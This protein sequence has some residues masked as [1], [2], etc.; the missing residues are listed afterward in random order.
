MASRPSPWATVSRQAAC[1][2]PSRP[3][4]W[5]APPWAAGPRHTSPGGSAPPS[6]SGCDTTASRPVAAPA[7]ATNWPVRVQT[8][9]AGDCFG[10]HVPQGRQPSGGGV[11]GE[12]RQ[13]VVAAVAHIQELPRRREVNL[14]ARVPGGV[15][16]GQ[17]RER[18]ESGEGARRRVQTIGRHT[19]PVLVRKIDDRKGGMKAIVAG[20]R[21]VAGS[22]WSG[23]L[24]VR[25]PVWASNFN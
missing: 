23:A 11:D 3:A 19:A 4:V 12:P 24:G 15:S 6:R 1:H 2:R 14:G 17:G 7:A 10:R 21:R 13:A 25:R 5:P 16:V 22:T 9:G 20:P 18:V 8:K